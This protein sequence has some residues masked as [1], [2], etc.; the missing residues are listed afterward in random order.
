LA[1]G[2]WARVVKEA[3][4]ILG[5]TFLFLRVA[6]AVYMGWIATQMF[7]R[8]QNPL[9]LLVFSASFL[10]VIQGQF[11][12]PTALGFAA[13]GAGLC[14]AATNE[15]T[16]VRPELAAVAATVPRRRGRSIFAERLHG[17]SFQ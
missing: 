8:R 12:Q 16:V 11:G 17:G 6:I 1:E 2:E 3:G 13:F 15:E 7:E 10:L 5:M 9:P 14:L 4:P